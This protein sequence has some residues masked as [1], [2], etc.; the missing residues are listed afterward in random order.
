MSPYLRLCITN[1]ITKCLISL[2]SQN[3]TDKVLYTI[4]DYLFIYGNTILYRAF[5]WSIY[6]LYDKNLKEQAIDKI[7]TILLDKLAVEEDLGTLCFFL[8]KYNRVGDDF[9][10]FNRKKNRSRN[11]INNNIFCNK[12]LIKMF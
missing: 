1:L 12:W 11:K 7:H 3:V 10:E 8:T 2:F 6:L 9:I 5:I 4:W